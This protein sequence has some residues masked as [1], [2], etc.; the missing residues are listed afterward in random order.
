MTDLIRKVTFGRYKMKSSFPK[1]NTGDTLDVHV[2]VKEGEKERIQLFKGIVMKIQGSGMGKSFTVRKIASG[3]GVEKTFPFTSPSI[4]KIKLVARGKVRR[5]RIFY[6]RGLKGRA[7]RLESELVREESTSKK[8][9]KKKGASAKA[10]IPTAVKSEVAAST[11]V[12]PEVATSA[13]AEVAK[14]SSD[15]KK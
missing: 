2:K 3:V 14:D 4:D 7:A 5:S 9:K 6:L 10:A 15:K 1:F 8:K 13:K 12:K 11:A